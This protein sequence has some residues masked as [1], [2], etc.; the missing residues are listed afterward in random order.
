MYSQLGLAFRMAGVNQTMAR[1]NGVSPKG[2]LLLALLAGN[3]LAGI[4]GALIT[5]SQGFADVHMGDPILITGLT[6]ILIGELFMRGKATS[7]VYGLAAVVIGSYLYRYLLALA[8]RLGVDPQLFNLLT[9]LI[10]VVA[11]TINLLASTASDRART[12]RLMRA[13]DQPP[14]SADVG[15]P[16]TQTVTSGVDTRA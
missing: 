9:A 10:I 13:L 12:R 4:S 5:Q 14:V 7:P 8:L 6:G 16:T 15:Q 2:M 3:A 11:I 1:A